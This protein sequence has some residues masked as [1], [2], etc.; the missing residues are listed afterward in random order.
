MKLRAAS[1]EGSMQTENRILNDLARVASSAFHTL[2]GVKDEIET[3]FRERLER[4]AAEME[5]VTREELDAVRAM[6]VKARTAQ[7]ALEAKVA[8]LETE[9]AELKAAQ[10]ARRPSA[11][12]TPK[13]T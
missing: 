3:R 4:L 1:R 11:P 7:E 9:L 6:A 5:L 8:A 2:G 12:K 13:P 10:P